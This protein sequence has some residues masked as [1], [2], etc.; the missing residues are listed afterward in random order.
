MHSTPGPRKAQQ[1]VEKHSLAAQV[2][3]SDGVENMD[4][5]DDEVDAHG[6]HYLQHGK[7]RV[8]SGPAVCVILKRTHSCVT[9]SKNRNVFGARRQV[10]IHMS[11][12]FL[13]VAGLI[14]TG[15]L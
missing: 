8:S 7:E 10:C 5:D 3:T 13:V 9:I 6:T 12:P 15:P 1:D 11:D 2:K 14:W 4:D